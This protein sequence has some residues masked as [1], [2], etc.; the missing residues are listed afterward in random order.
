MAPKDK[1][2]ELAAGT[3]APQRAILLRLWGLMMAITHRIFG[4]YVGGD[5][6]QLLMKA[7][8]DLQK[9]ELMCR[10]GVAR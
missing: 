3:R 1:S 4:V 9:G 6:E 2:L 5:V 7:Q 8:L 10:T